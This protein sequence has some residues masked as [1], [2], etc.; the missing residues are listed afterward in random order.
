M[1]ASQEIFGRGMMN[2]IRQTD[3]EQLQRLMQ[4]QQMN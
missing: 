3:N 1:R 2:G 4:M